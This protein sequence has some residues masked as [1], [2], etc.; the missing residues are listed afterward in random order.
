MNVDRFDA[1]F[2]CPHVKTVYLDWKYV[3]VDKWSMLATNTGNACGIEHPERIR[4]PS[5]IVTIRRVLRRMCGGSQAF[6]VE[7]GDDHFYV[8]KFFDNPQGNRTLINEWAVHR[9]LQQLG[10]STPEMRVLRLTNT[11][12]GGGDLCFQTTGRSRPIRGEF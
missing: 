2:R 8:A 3:V 10:I 7:G 4:M 11:T 1:L 6:L 12:K 9:V 5:E